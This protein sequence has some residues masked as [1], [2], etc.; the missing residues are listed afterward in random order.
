MPARSLAA[1]EGVQIKIQSRIF[2]D[3]TRAPSLKAFR[4]GLDTVPMP[5]ERTCPEMHPTTRKF[6]SIP[7]S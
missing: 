6:V 5:N 3:T 1:L 2:M 7:I 4:E